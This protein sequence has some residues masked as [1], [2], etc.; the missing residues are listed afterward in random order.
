MQTQPTIRRHPP[1]GL[2]LGASQEALPLPELTLF[3][4]DPEPMPKRPEPEPQFEIMIDW[5]LQTR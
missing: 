3:E 2:A 4:G 1:S 5:T